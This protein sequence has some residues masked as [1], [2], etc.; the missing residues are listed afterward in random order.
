MIHSLRTHKSPKKVGIVGYGVYV[1]PFRITSAEIDTHQNKRVGITAKSTGLISKSVPAIDEDTITIATIAAQQALVRSK[2]STELVQSLF[3][4]SES[5]PYAVKPSGATVAAA[6]GLS[7]N[8][9]TADLEFA[10]KAGTQALQIATS[11]VKAGMHTYSMAIG[12]DTAQAAP[13]D[14]LEYTAAAG[15][16]AYL[17][18]SR[19]ILAEIVATTSVVTDTPDFWRANGAAYPSH[20]GR[21]TGEPAYFAHITKSVQR[22]FE[23]TGLSAQSIDY[24]VF[25]TPNVKFP[26]AIAH[27]L[28]FSSKQLAPSL[29]VQTVGNTYS[30]ASMLALAQTLDTI[31][32]NKTILVA[33]YGSGAGS[34]AFLLKT[35]PLLVAQRSQWKELLSHQ[36]A[37]TTEISYTQYLK[38][39]SRGHE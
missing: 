37:T 15:G 3:I 27:S 1:P 21:F 20:A 16:A 12:A 18:G 11:F 5:H 29:L 31:E 19:K 30:A 8:M 32:A 23:T 24:C 17:V 36:L 10:C 13:G 26:Q 33:S 14:A 39:T 6:L 25:H 2:I 9:S 7:E 28:G 34:D 22:L 35:T 4:G 38:H